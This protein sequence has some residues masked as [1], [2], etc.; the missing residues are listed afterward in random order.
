MKIEDF[1]DK[2]FIR[3]YNFEM[4]TKILKFLIKNNHFQ[5]NI[6]FNGNI[7]FYYPKN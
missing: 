7:Q 6:L 1:V 2:E 4:T 5:K 3:E